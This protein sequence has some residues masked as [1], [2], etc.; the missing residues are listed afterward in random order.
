MEQVRCRAPHLPFAHAGIG[1]RLRNKLLR[2]I[3]AHAL[4]SLNDTAGD[5]AT[6]GY[7]YAFEHG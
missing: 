2:A 6:V 5:L 3:N 7:E 4:S 1:R